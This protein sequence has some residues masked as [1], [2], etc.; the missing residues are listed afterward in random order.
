MTL[1]E[2]SKLIADFL[3]W[4]AYEN[5]VT[6]KFPNLYPIHNIDSPENTGWVSDHISTALFDKSYDWLMPV[7]QKLKEV[8]FLDYSTQIRFLCLLKSCS[9]M[10]IDEDLQAFYCD[11]VNCVDFINRMNKTKLK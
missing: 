4:D 2:E 10:L 7:Y 6:Y 9:E 5:G 3:G 8:E 11:I 1:I